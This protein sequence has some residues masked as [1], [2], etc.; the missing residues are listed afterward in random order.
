MN[1]G[2]IPALVKLPQCS[3]VVFVQKYV[4]EWWREAN[5]EFFIL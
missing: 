3:D 1:E 5:Q 4:K 2:E